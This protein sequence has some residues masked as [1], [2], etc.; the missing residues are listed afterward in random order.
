[1]SGFSAVTVADTLEVDMYPVFEPVTRTEM[2]LLASAETSLYEEEVAPEIVF[3]SRNH[4]YLKVDPLVQVPGFAVRVEPTLA[5]PVMVGTAAVRV[6]LAMALV[7][8]E[9]FATDV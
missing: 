8:G 7:L 9:V 1:M 5:V 3:P 4:W 2:V 6:P